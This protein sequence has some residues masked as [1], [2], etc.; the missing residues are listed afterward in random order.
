MHSALRQPCS[1]PVN[2]C[3][4]STLKNWPVRTESIRRYRQRGSL[5]AIFC[6][7]RASWCGWHVNPFPWNLFDSSHTLP[8]EQTYLQASCFKAP[9]YYE[10]DSFI[11]YNFITHP[12]NEL[13]SGR[14]CLWSEHLRRTVGYRQCKGWLPSTA[15]H[16]CLPE[17]HQQL[18]H[19]TARHLRILKKKTAAKSLSSDPLKMFQMFLTV[20]ARICWPWTG[21]WRQN[22]TL[23]WSRLRSCG[24][25]LFCCGRYRHGSVPR[26]AHSYES[27]AQILNIRLWI[28]H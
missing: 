5:V 14:V 7:V 1:C 19:R 10:I 4:V 21:F 6:T 8:D 16:L 9:E 11:Y 12:H 27:G 15:I 18:F 17:C 20:W 28:R 13:L 26:A 24:Y 25:R 22:G 23:R 3:L 2:R